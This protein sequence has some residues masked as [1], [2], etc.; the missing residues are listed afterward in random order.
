MSSPNHLKLN[1]L[2]KEIEQLRIKMVKT[3]NKHGYT[4]QESIRI[5]QELDYL[6]NVY[7]SL[8]S[9]EKEL[10]SKHCYY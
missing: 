9:D 3:A 10:C 5:S 1:Q 8:V 2:Q 6:L 7:Q 4:S